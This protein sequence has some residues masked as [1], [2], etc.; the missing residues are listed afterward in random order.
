MRRNTVLL[1]SAIPRHVW[2]PTRHNPNWPDSYG[3][4]IAD[5]RH[6]PAKKWSVGLE[7][8]TPSE[9]LQYSKRNLAYAYNGTLR[10]CSSFPEMVKYYQEMKQ[11]GVK[12]DLDTMNIIL[13]RA[14]RYEKI[15]VEDIFQLFDELVELGA[16]PDI[17]TAETLHTVWEGSKASAADWREARRRHLVALYNALAEEDI[18]RYGKQNADHL[19]AAQIGRYRTNLKGLNASLSPSVHKKYLAHLN[20]S[21]FLVSEVNSF[22]WEFVEDNHAFVNIDA[23]NI[24]VPFVASVLKRPTP[25]SD[26]IS[27]TQFEDSDVC[28]VILS[29]VERLVDSPMDIKSPAQ[30]RMT[31]L[32][33]I[34]LTTSSG[35]LVTS[36]LMAQM[37]EVAKFSK[38]DDVTRDKDATRLLSLAL[39]GSH[40]K[41]DD[42][43]REKWL[44]IAQPCDGRVVGRYLAARDPWGE[45]RIAPQGFNFPKYA[46]AEASSTMPLDATTSS[47]AAANK[48]STRTLADLQQRWADAQSLVQRAEALQGHDKAASVEVFT[49]LT[50][51]LKHLCYGRA[52]GSSFAGN[53]ITVDMCTSI[54]TYLK[55]TKL[56]LDAYCAEHQVEPELECWESMVQIL[57][58]MLDFV[59]LQRRHKSNAPNVEALDSLFK[60]IAEFR[61][62]VL[63]ESLTRFQGRFRMLWLQEA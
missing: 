37:M 33:L 31:L 17:A 59:A 7:P 13:T 45:L 42:E 48:S 51:F 5:R 34:A 58:S 24:Q 8:R 30:E 29:A 23:L 21:K 49:G 46:V 32:S 43:Q 38:V 15:E 25:R 60:E 52:G 9:W 6:W 10:A 47:D 11:R 4:E 18:A 63:D 57:R 41:R 54:F 56:Q 19:L 36:D 28:S 3:T 44:A 2:D 1:A 26:N 35:V 12:V 20:L 62:G 22:L 61:S 39:R 53:G 40:S 55:E 27:L 14:A 16:K 50:V